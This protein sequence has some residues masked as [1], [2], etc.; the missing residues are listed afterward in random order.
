[1]NPGPTRSTGTRKSTL[2]RFA[3]VPD[4]DLRSLV[5]PSYLERPDFQSQGFSHGDA[6]GLL[7]TGGI[8]QVRAKWCGAVE[9]ITGLSVNEDT[10]HAAGLVLIRTSLHVY[11]MCYG[12]G[13]HML[14]WYY[15]DDEFG[16]EFATRCLD[17]DGVVK[18]RNQIMDSR[19]RVD[20]YSVARA[21][22][23][24]GFGI[25]R[26]GSVIRRLC[27]TVSEIPLTRLSSGKTRS[28]RA[29]CSPVSIKLPL[30]TSN[31]A[32]LDDL[33]TIEE[34]CARPDPL[35]EL[36]FIDRVRGLDNRSRKAVEA[37]RQL[38]TMLADRGHLKLGLGVPEACQEEFGSAQAF[39]IRLGAKLRRV[40]DL[41]LPTILDFVADR[42]LGQR[43]KA[44]SQVKIEM[45]DEED[46][47]EQ[48]LGIITSAKDWLIADVQVETERFF[49]S[50]SKWY[51]AGTGFV[52][53]LEDELQQLFAKRS[54]IHLP[55]WPA[56]I[57]EDKYNEKVAKERGFL[58]FD[59]KKNTTKKFRGGGL[60]ICDALGPDNQLVFVKKATSGTA[61]LNHLFAQ[62]VTAVEALRNDV[63]I[64]QK[65]MTHVRDRTPT[66]RLLSD[67]GSLKVVL[68]ILLKDGSDITVDSL[69][70]FAQVSLLTA[71][72]RLRA[73]NAEV[74]V[75]AIR[76]Q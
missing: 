19:G 37:Q 16:L 40:D 58:L 44:L 39:E 12:L 31:D 47:L 63:D 26:F 43:F 8:P 73:M 3:A 66:H 23:I 62:A 1:M 46:D 14:D 30:A 24:D 67:F 53:I 28:L 13:H 2:Y 41:D 21:E 74:E 60:E 64:R 52:R 45:L 55:T 76:R 4:N 27:G 34:V 5:R 70:A 15:L 59:K 57:D 25:D 6:V 51:E 33:R 75:V 18:I 54:G 17:E 65:F 38:E 61:P 72:R 42:P 7:V 48:P 71:A 35:P 36:G 69:F 22:R 29:D 56:G 10:R 50:H 49:F 68:A 11:G 32:F 20:E 9:G